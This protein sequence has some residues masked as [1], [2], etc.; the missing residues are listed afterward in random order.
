MADAKLTE[1]EQQQV[2]RWF[3]EFKTA[4]QARTLL[5]QQ[6]G[7][8]VSLKNVWAYTESKKWRPMIER[9]RQ[10]WVLG[11]MDVPLAHKRTRLEKLVT[12]LE[13]AERNKDVSEYRKIRQCTE[14]LHEMRDEMEVGKTQFT[15][16]YLTTIHQYSDEELL[17]RRDE[18]LNRL[19]ELRRV[20]HGKRDDGQIAV[21]ASTG[22]PQDALPVGAG[23]DGDGGGLH[24]RPHGEGHP[25]SP[26]AP[27]VL[28]DAPETRTDS[29]GP[30]A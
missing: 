29:Q 18:V 5:R 7:K 22:P 11:V 19:Q 6:C 4:T 17:R 12:L 14:I 10:Q 8:D 27:G 16:V 3:A 9:L 23:T 1:D 13:R 20:P 28:S 24:Q 15:N 2:C 30:G 26:E 21:E 25:E